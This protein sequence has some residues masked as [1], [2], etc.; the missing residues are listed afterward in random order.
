MDNQEGT[1]STSAA[2]GQGSGTTYTD[3]AGIQGSTAGVGG[4]R[5]PGQVG[6]QSTRLERWWCAI[7]KPFKCIPRIIF[8]RNSKTSTK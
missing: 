1:G 3:L 7:L 8:S 5:V 4:R 6:E 2:L